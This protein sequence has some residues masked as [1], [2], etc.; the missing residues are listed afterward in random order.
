MRASRIFLLAVI[1][2]V[3]CSGERPLPDISAVVD[4]AVA[5]SATNEKQGGGL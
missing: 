3:G 1:P 4:E 2:L 5:I